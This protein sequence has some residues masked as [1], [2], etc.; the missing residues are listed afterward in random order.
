MKNIILVLALLPMTSIAAP[1]KKRAPSQV[2]ISANLEKGIK[3]I[4]ECHKEFARDLDQYVHCAKNVFSN[5]ADRVDRLRQSS[6]FVPLTVK[7][8]GVRLCNSV[9]KSFGQKDMGA[10]EVLMCM[11]FTDAMGTPRVA[12]IRSADGQT[13][14]YIRAF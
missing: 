3:K 13:I 10:E 6:A 4:F 5:S 7:R 2:E 9:E 8:E 11:S 12:F 1:K 14:T